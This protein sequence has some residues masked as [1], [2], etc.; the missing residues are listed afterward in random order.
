[1]KHF[2]QSIWNHDA[3]ITLQEALGYLED[4]DE[5]Q[6]E[7]YTIN[8]IRRIV[9]KYPNVFYPIY[10]LQI[11]MIES[12]FGHYWWDNHK[13]QMHEK[14]E[15]EKLQ[16]LAEMRRRQQNEEVTDEVA[17][18]K[19]I[20]KRLGIRFYLMPWLIETEKRKMAKIA[21][22]EKELDMCIGKRSSSGATFK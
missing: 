14:K 8:L 10:K 11:N 5:N 6:T 9:K 22:I 15:E 4:H 13:A 19:I 2:L 21:A 3:P 12:T 18:M 7:I 20:K 1:M 17:T 16:H